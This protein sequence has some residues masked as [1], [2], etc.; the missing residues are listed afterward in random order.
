MQTEPITIRVEAEAAKA[1][2]SASPEKRRKLELL[3]GM[4]LL[5]SARG[6]PAL[7]QIMDE[8][9]RNAQARGLTP[10]ILDELLNE[11]ES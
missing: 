6:G 7:D 2:R 3:L 9:S 4:Q 8:I 1:F 11:K 5:E 10:E